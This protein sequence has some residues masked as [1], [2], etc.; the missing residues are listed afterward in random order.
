MSGAE[1]SNNAGNTLFYSD[2]KN[3]ENIIGKC[4]DLS[5]NASS[6]IWSTE[7]GAEVSWHFKRKELYIQMHGGEGVNGLPLYLAVSAVR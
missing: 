3:C 4:E 5:Y 6:F 1:C 7:V 2:R